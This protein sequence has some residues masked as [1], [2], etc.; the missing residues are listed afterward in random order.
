MPKIVLINGYPMSGKDTFVELCEE[1]A[2]VTNLLTST[3]AKLALKTLGWNGDKTPE[4]RNL[5]AYLMDKSYDLFDGPT[6]Y[7]K[8]CINN[9][10]NSDII[11]VHVREPR[12]ID[13]LKKLLGEDVTTL[14][15]IRDEAVPK[16]YSNDSDNNVE[17]YEYDLYVDNNG[18]LE[19]LKDSA[20]FIVT[21]ILTKKEGLGI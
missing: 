14:F 10:R 6:K 5:L 20:A 17:D 8:D 13:R 3:P 18:T 19:D 11:F 21:H 2:E 9:S 15:I 12:N 7:I 16:S 4:A 1:S